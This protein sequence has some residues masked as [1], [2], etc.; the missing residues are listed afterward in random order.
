MDTV[1]NFVGLGSNQDYVPPRLYIGNAV[2]NRVYNVG[3][4]AIRMDAEA[5]ALIIK[6]KQ[7]RI[8][9]KSLHNIPFVFS[10][11]GDDQV[12]TEEAGR[13]IEH[14][15]NRTHFQTVMQIDYDA[16]EQSL[17]LSGGLGVK[18][19][20]THLD[21]TFTLT[22]VQPN[23]LQFTVTLGK[24]EPPMTDYRRILLTFE[25]RT[26][27]H[28]Y[29]FGEQYGYSSLKGHKVPI[30]TRRPSYS[31]NSGF[32]AH[33]SSSFN[34]MM[35][36]AYENLPTSVAVPQFI[37]TDNRCF[38]LENSEYGHFDL[39]E[40]DRVTVRLN[41]TQMT[42]R[43]F[44]G[45]SMLD[46]LSEYTQQL[47]GR[48]VSLPSWAFK[49]AIISLQGG[50]EKIQQIVTRIQE[51][52]VPVAAI[53]ITD[54]FG[55]NDWQINRALYPNWDL[56]IDQ[57]SN[58]NQSTTLRVLVEVHGIIKEN[59][60]QNSNVF[61]EAHEKGYLLKNRQG[62]NWIMEDH[63]KR[64]GNLVDLTN[65]EARQWLKHIIKDR[66]W[67]AGISGIVTN[68]D[69]QYLIPG[70]GHISF[71]SG[72]S[73]DSYKSRYAD[74][75]AQLHREV[76]RE[77]DM[78][79][80]TAIVHTSGYMRAPGYTNA[81]LVNDRDVTWDAQ[82]GL[83]SAIAGML[84]AG[85]SGYSVIHSDIGGT[86]AHTAALPG[87]H[88][89]SRSRELLH[90]WMELSAFT[91]LFKTAEESFPQRSYSVTD[92]MIQLAHTAQL[93]TSLTPYRNHLFQEAM[94]KGWPVMRHLIMYYPKDAVVRELSYQQFLLGSCLLVA[95]VTTPSASFTKVYFPKEENRETTWRHIWTGKYY[96]ADGSYI[97]VDAPIGRPPVFVKE[98]REDDGLLNDLL[99]YAIQFVQRSS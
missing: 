64:K 11:L 54:C 89:P 7:D 12:S 36:G 46:V 19:I 21:Y 79:E 94:E 13:I 26:N 88:P 76:V 1:L 29:G 22:A 8:V 37:S 99:D 73:I 90:R 77:L 20:S 68:A 66:V 6:D 4:F 9:W 39:R 96:P 53:C 49:G 58:Q 42:G 86:T 3:E 16:K 69:D 55:E 48:M 34:S 93:Y 47:S 78:E 28:F 83:K 15:E 61:V 84:C 35:T 2:P 44:N 91:A 95:P 43:M 60:Q 30:Q 5:R 32:M 56:F 82:H 81:M 97:A 45:D 71:D 80:D 75:W 38:F 65:P 74:D 31:K 92:S 41:S 63:E 50:Q 57:L 67:T 27:E 98:P 62:Y 18:L 87:N 72:E 33:L 59:N 23:Q 25:S 17:K 51:F 52:K 85:F 70:A 14:D 40:S 10:S 24:A